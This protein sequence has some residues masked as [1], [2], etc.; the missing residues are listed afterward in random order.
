[1]QRIPRLHVKTQ[2]AAVLE[3]LY[4][5]AVSAEESGHIKLNK[6]NHPEGP[7]M[8][9]SV[10]ILEKKDNGVF[11][12]VAH[13]YEQN[14]DLVPD[15][16]M[17]FFRSNSKDIDSG[18]PLFIPVEFQDDRRFDEAVEFDGAG[19][20]TR[21]KAS[22][23]NDLISFS[24][25]WMKNIRQQQAIKPA[26]YTKKENLQKK[27][28]QRYKRVTE[29]AKEMGFNSINEAIAAGKEAELNAKLIAE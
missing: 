14:G 20:V 27:L 29:A 26:E 18:L 6:G 17:T 15:P 8:P 28:L 19:F 4:Q 11:M 23:V 25:L 10:E 1:M 16:T 22:L 5:M 7:I 12:A 13:Y 3:I 9:V 24:S 21:Y 2:A